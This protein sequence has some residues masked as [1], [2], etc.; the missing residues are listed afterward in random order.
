M[1]PRRNLL[2]KNKTKNFS[3]VSTASI[4][5]DGDSGFLQN[6]K[7]VI[8]MFI[9]VTTSKSVFFWLFFCSFTEVFHRLQFYQ[10]RRFVDHWISWL[11]PGQC[12]VGSVVMALCYSRRKDLV[13]WKRYVNIRLRARRKFIEGGINID[14]NIGQ[15]VQYVYS[16][17]LKIY[18]G[19][20]YPFGFSAV[21]FIE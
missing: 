19:F 20:C 17:R 16:V 15:L 18:G 4:I 21:I 11:V 5:R 10:K 14:I 8:L 1:I 2:D 6:D 12:W 3:H 13:R 7:S 9:A